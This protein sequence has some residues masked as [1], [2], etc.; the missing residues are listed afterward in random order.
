[1]KRVMVV[2]FASALVLVPPALS[3]PASSTSTAT[4][5]AAPK[6]VVIGSSTNIAGQVTGKKAAGATVELQ[7]KPFPYSGA[8]STVATTAANAAGHYSFN[9]K[10]S[11]NTMYRVSAKT[12]P[13]ATSPDVLVQVRVR[14]TQHVST[15]N[16]A[17][18][19]LVR[20]SGFVYPAYT[21]KTVQIQ[22]RTATG[23]RTVARPTLVSAAT[24]NG[25]TRSKYSKRLRIR[26]S[27]TYR[28]RFNPADGARLANTSPSRR[29]T[30]H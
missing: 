16:P 6:V 14:V 3:K 28:V 15:L 17:A 9:V 8:F 18:G 11:L 22:R 13:T 5:G 21:G 23:W 27:G 7:A 29:L 20:F 10:P 19:A 4:I 26:H 1:M 2:V 25:Q 30:V 12:S 24:V